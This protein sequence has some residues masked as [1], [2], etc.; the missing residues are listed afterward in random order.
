MAG[1][2]LQHPNMVSS[3]LDRLQGDIPEG[4]VNAYLA[5]K[6]STKAYDRR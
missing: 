5:A 4:K 6:P 3:S 1:E 2:R